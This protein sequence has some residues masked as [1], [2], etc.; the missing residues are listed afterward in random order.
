M[1]SNKPSI[2]VLRAHFLIFSFWSFPF[3]FFPT[4]LITHPKVTP[5][6]HE[7]GRPS[8]DSLDTMCRVLT[9]VLPVSQPGSWR[10]PVTNSR[11]KRKRIPNTNS[12]CV[13]RGHHVLF[14][15]SDSFP[16]RPRSLP[17]TEGTNVHL[18]LPPVLL[19][20]IPSLPLITITPLHRLKITV[21]SSIN[22]VY[23]KKTLWSK[24]SESV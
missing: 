8:G 7:L 9:G 22:R 2:R 18:S 6:D 3:Q 14:W 19:H 21:R 24:R 1:S 17:F 20:S 11:V 10:Q 12:I 15:K 4:H 16:L 13:V 23:G 5:V